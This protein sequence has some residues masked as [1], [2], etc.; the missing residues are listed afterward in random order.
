MGENPILFALFFKLCHYLKSPVTFVFVF[1]RPHIPEVKHG[2]CIKGQDP[3]LIEALKQLID[4]F[5]FY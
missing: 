1:D 2:H 3:G 4:M 5:G